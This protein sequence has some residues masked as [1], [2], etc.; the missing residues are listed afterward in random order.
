MKKAL[1]IFAVFSLLFAG[2]ENPLME[3][4]LGSEKNGGE[5]TGWE[6]VIAPIPPENLPTA[7]R[8][9]TWID[10]DSTANI[11]ISVDE[12]GVCAITVSGT[13][14][15]GMPAWDN[16]WRVNASYAYTATAGKTY[17]YTFEAWTKDGADRTMTVQ[18]YNDYEK[19]RYHNTG[20]YD[21][22]TK[23]PT[24]KITSTQ[25]IYTIKASD[26]EN[27]PIPKSGVQ[28][29]EFQCANQLG[30][31]YVRIISIEENGGGETDV[32]FDLYTAV[33][34]FATAIDDITISVPHNITMSDVNIIIPA[35]VSGKTLTITSASFSSPRTLS[36][37]SEDTDSDKGLFI[38]SDGA[39]LVF[40]N[41]IIDGKKT[42]HT[43]NAASLVR[44]E[45]GSTFTLGNGA[46]LRNN[47]ASYGGGVYVAG[48]YGGNGGTFTM[49][50]GEISNNTAYS[51]GGVSVGDGGEFNMSGSAKVL[52]N[53]VGGNG[54][55][56]FV[57]GN[58]GNGDTIPGT[59]NMFDDAKV[60]GN[61][62]TGYGGGVYILGSFNMNG[63]EIDGGNSAANGGGVYVDGGTF[64]M[65]NGKILGNT[66]ASNGGGVHVGAYGT[67]YI[68]NGIVYGSTAAGGMANTA[69]S[70]G[71]ALFVYVDD[72][73]VW[74]KGTAQCKD[75]SDTITEDLDTITDNTIRVVNGALQ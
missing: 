53:T 60:S 2:C 25:R 31:F 37:G 71:A 27:D 43:N 39:K 40:E 33:A 38:V 66:A 45:S 46:V 4:I 57:R 74:S 62:A 75:S 67:F 24:F 49:S 7:E 65:S 8:W 52:G 69:T 63:G 73:D 58:G 14:M 56:V 28:Q 30:T 23:Q 29:L 48:I 41:I 36:R 5:Q 55:G 50:G 44:L 47:K 26:Y 42:T 17:T 35:N 20:Y 15:T 22:T 1:L 59:F 10:G 68:V 6:P 19:E 72:D 34:D 13:A 32:S 3:K 51:G 54:G 9:S 61:T 16:V 18:W 64:S 21:Q 12:E 11:D 70:Q